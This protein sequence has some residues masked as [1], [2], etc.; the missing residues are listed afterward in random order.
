MRSI[1][2]FIQ[3]YIDGKDNFHIEVK[4]NQLNLNCRI[5]IQNTIGYSKFGIMQVNELSKAMYMNFDS[6]KFTSKSIP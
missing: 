6:N 1:K 5:D 3:I 2:N 4:D